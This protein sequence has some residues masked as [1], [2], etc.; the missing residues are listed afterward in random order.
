[1]TGNLKAFSTA[2]MRP[3]RLN[4]RRAAPAGC[5]LT[6]RFVLVEVGQPSN[7]VDDVC[8]LVHDYDGCCPQAR[9]RLLEGVKVH[10]HIV[11]D[12][13]RQAWH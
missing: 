2:A 6:A 7:G 8:G 4:G 11:A 9:L 1:M 3:G 12:V 10:E 5:A 13:L